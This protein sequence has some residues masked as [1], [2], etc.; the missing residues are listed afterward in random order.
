M[1]F[2][3]L[4]N[5][6]QTKTL[7]ADVERLTA[8]AAADQEQIA[9]LIELVNWFHSRWLTVGHRDIEST[10]TVAC[11][12]E[13]LTDA[14]RKLAALERIAGPHVDPATAAAPLYDAVVAERSGETARE[15]RAIAAAEVV[16]PVR[17]VTLVKPL[18]D[19]L[20]G[21]R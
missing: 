1:R 10:L 11:L 20:G 6:G 4:K 5:C 16:G 19:A 13:R 7:R 17:T 9:E 2:H 12:E 3:L 15:F 14:N 21:V 8:E 18:A